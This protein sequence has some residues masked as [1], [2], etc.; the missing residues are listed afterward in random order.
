[1]AYPN[2]L[3]CLEQ[4][5]V[6]FL[7]ETVTDWN[8]FWV[9][10]GAGAISAI[11][12]IIAVWY[13]NKKTRKLYEETRTEE[14]KQNAMAV[15]KP[16]LRNACFWE[17]KDKMIL[18]G[19]EERMLLLSSK[20]DG[21]GFYDDE[22]RGNERHC[23]ILICNESINRIEHIS[24]ST[25]T[26]LTKADDAEKKGDSDN[27]VKLLRKGETI[28]LRIHSEEQHKTHWECLE[29]KETVKTEFHCTINYLTE[30]GQQ[31]RYEYRVIIT[32]IPKTD[33]KGNTT[34]NRKTEIITDEYEVIVGSSVEK[35]KPASSFRDLQE[36]LTT[37]GFGYRYR[38]IG[39]EQ[40][41]GTLTALH[42]F[43][44]DQK[45]DEFVGGVANTANDMNKTM[46]DVASKL[47]SQQEFFE[48]FLTWMRNQKAT[49]ALELKSTTEV[50]ESNETEV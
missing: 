5:V 33:D 42:R 43:W 26:T 40:M 3:E 2:G 47:D 32:D 27:I 20:K 9:A 30:A 45:M 25:S 10:L 7:V 29:K 31:I 39:D 23:I 35:G 4:T 46:K 49:T 18:D 17:I 19:N 13:T 6:P 1:M 15:V 50:I 16:S 24:I 21:F 34:Y 41:Q 12:T 28:L 38:R 36:R 8:M 22:K 44:K 37:D 11:A 48:E 14:R